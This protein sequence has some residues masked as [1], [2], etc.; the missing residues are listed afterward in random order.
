MFSM[1]DIKGIFKIKII[2]NGPYM[3]TGFVP[4]TK[5]TILADRNGLSSSWKTSHRYPVQE[6]YS[7]CR[8]GK[9]QNKPYCDGIHMHAK[10]IGTETAST[11]KYIDQAEVI[12]GADITLTDVVNLCAFAQ[13]CDRDGGVWQLTEYSEDPEARDM[14]IQEA[15]DCPAGRLVM[16]DKKTGQTIEPELEPSIGLIEDPQIGVSGPIWVKGGIPIEASDGTVYEV[17]NRVT[18]C[19]CGRS[20]NKPFCDGIHAV[21]GARE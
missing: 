20:Q 14:A 8:C 16:W 18:L 7:L 4:M 2:K 11:E 21:K 12:E 1:S 17:R 10:F 15:C 19:R 6:K 3:V 5:Q 13:F 9:S